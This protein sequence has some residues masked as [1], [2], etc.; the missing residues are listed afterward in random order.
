[1][2]GI[3]VADPI[4]QYEKDT[5][6]G[7]LPL[8]YVIILM[9]VHWDLDRSEAEDQRQ[10]MTTRETRGSWWR[11]S[12]T[13]TMKFTA[14]VLSMC[15]ASAAAFAPSKFGIV[16]VRPVLNPMGFLLREPQRLL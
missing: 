4:S 7:F 8:T 13:K 12:L 16:R 9:E 15:V 6:T 1:M 10:T 2:I 14:G 3:L 5:S 11:H